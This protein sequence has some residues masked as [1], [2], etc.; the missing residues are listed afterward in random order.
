MQNTLETNKRTRLERLGVI[1]FFFFLIIG[2]LL[3][4]LLA[5]KS[6]DSIKQALL[7]RSSTIASFVG[8]QDIS[9][10]QEGVF[11]TNSQKYTDLKRKL[12]EANSFSSN[13][14]SIYIIVKKNT[15]KF[16]Y[17][18]DSQSPDSE[19][20]IEPGREYQLNDESEAYSFNLGIPYI[21]G[22]Y[23]DEKGEWV[24]AFA[25][26][27]KDGSTLAFVGINMFSEEYQNTWWSI[28]FSTF[29]AGV[30]VALLVLLFTVYLK[31][32]IH[33]VK[34]VVSERAI[35]ENQKKNIEETNAKA[36]VGYFKWNRSTGD[37]MLSEFIL[38][39][40]Q[41]EDGI[42]FET[43][44]SHVSKDEIDMLEKKILDV[45]SE[46]GKNLVCELNYALPTGNM[47]RLR[48]TC[49]FSQIYQNNP[50]FIEGT[51]LQ[52]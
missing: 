36:G 52:I 30:L 35:V 8:P 32:A 15:D 22:P 29:A 31:R 49:N 2:L 17:Y 6:T 12:I 13:T 48:L 39:T 33:L 10:L 34:R 45:C 44:K 18:V 27:K 23:K 25:P 20:Y 51:I 16:F 1:L 26:I 37:L 9:F 42:N 40:L 28:F 14:L 50:K 47:K 21:K 3:G 4:V 43:F 41:L 46:G 11:D 38:K 24:T 7:V 5:N 19:F